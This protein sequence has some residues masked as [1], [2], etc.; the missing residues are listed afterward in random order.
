MEGSITKTS[1]EK[2]YEDY[3]KRKAPRVYLSEPVPTENNDLTKVR[4]FIEL[5]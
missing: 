1:V 3:S 2:F 5:G 4:I